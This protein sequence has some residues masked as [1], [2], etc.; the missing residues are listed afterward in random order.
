ML[1]VE[2]PGSTGDRGSIMRLSEGNANQS[3]AKSNPE[4]DWWVSITDPGPES[5]TWD[6]CLTCLDTEDAAVKSPHKMFCKKVTASCGPAKHGLWKDAQ[7][8]W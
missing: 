3:N 6:N 7:L 2:D 5:V 4:R 1:V 8:Q